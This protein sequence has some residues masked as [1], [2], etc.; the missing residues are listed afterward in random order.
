MKPVFDSVGQT[1]HQP[2]T[3][4]FNIL[5]MRLDDL[6]LSHTLQFLIPLSN[7]LDW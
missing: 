1:G 2:Q 3:P 6:R 5:G 4:V 7:Q